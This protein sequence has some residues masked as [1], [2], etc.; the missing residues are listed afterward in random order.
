LAD[1][2]FKEY[3]TLKQTKLDIKLGSDK[4]FDAYFRLHKVPR[5]EGTT[6]HGS[7]DFSSINPTINK[8]SFF[9]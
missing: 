6:T 4:G 3:Y 5:P 1:Y 9:E 2:D 8:A 7:F